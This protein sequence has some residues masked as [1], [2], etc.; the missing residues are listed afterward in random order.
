VAKVRTF[1]AVELPPEVVQALTTVQEKLR[2]CGAKVKWVEPRNLHLTMKFLGDVDYEKVPEISAAIA[3]CVSDAPPLMVR[4]RGL[5]TFPPG[6]RAPRVVWVALEGAL[7]RL[8]KTADRL[9]ESLVRFGVPYEKRRFS[10]HITIGRVKSSQGAHRLVEAIEACGQAEFGEVEIDELAFMMS[11]L[12]G[13]G[14][15]YTVL[16]KVPFDRA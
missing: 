10:P 3:Q 6:R 7:E 1:V 15:V 11:E 4:V 14:P 12:T 8:E 2:G 5:G 13:K 16:S 9:N